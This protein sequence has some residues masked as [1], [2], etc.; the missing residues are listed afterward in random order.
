[1]D[2]QARILNGIQSSLPVSVYATD[3]DIYVDICDECYETLGMPL[4]WVRFA[5]QGT[6]CCLCGRSTPSFS[7]PKDGGR[8]GQE[9]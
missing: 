3:E 8:K 6:P 1:M 9:P 4:D 2:A 5:P 7:A